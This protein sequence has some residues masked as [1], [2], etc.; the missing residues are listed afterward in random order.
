[1]LNYEI[2]P[3]LL[4]P[5]VPHGVELDGYDGRTYVSMV[6]F[7]FLNTR[8]L[9]WRIPF[10]VNFDEVNLRFYV[11]RETPEG[12]QRGVVFIK[13][14]VPKWAIAKVARWIYNEKYVACPM[15][16]L[17]TLPAGNNETTGF[18][19]YRWKSLRSWNKVS[20][21][22][23]G[24][25]KLPEPGS[26]EAFITEHY[27]GYTVQRNGSTL[28]YRV[29]HPQWKVWAATET[30]V[31]CDVGEF[32]GPQFVEALSQKPTSVFVADGSVIEVLKGQSLRSQ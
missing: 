26:E 4:Q 5:L 18:V 19:E 13:E 2:D 16:S 8:V 17:L 11:R 22:F 20:A 9:G 30:T 3:E 24:E 29:S 23:A 7:R 15:A 32:Y 31:E 10:H 21:K 28:E 12:F 14:I 1:M 27:W 25:A 6:G